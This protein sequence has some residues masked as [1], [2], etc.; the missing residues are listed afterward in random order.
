VA[1]EIDRVLDERNSGD[2]NSSPWLYSMFIEHIFS[3][4]SLDRLYSVVQ[5]GTVAVLV[6]NVTLLYDT[7]KTFR[8]T[9]D[10]SLAAMVIDTREL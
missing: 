7:P 2:S 10:A 9:I 5:S 1:R 3:K 8:T 6:G 4:Q